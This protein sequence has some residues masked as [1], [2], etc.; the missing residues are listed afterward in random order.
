MADASSIFA[1]LMAVIEQRRDNPPEK[2]YTNTLLAGGV[3][4]IGGKIREE[5]DE[6]I[7][8]AGEPGDAG[9]DHT[10]R[11]AGDVIYHLWVLLALRQIGVAD[12]EAELERRF[13]TSGIDEK[14]SRTTSAA[15]PANTD[16]EQAKGDVERKPASDFPT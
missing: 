11:E 15:G 3:E 9:R 16:V 10:V 8:A 2:S 13:G 6:V 5:A 4:K 12:L 7:E 14:A 1:R